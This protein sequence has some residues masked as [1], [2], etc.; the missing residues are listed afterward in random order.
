MS[1]L[2]QTKKHT[3]AEYLA[4]EE[5]AKYRSEYW[6][7]E[8]VAMSGAKIDH[9][10]IIMNISRIL[11]NKLYGK[12][13]LFASEMKVWVKKRNKFFYPD[14]TLICEKPSFYKNRRDTID[15]PKLIVEVLSKSTASFDRAEK[16]LSYQS[17]DS[18]DEY[19]LVSQ[20]KP[21][22]EQYIKRE[23]GNW[24]YK[25]TIGLESTVTFSAVEA[26]LTLQEIYD[27]VEFEEVE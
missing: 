27:L 16:F 9:Q 2:T 1:V 3:P 4:L 25:A 18:L 12:C 15:N 21:L 22:V 13:R 11:G 8:I 20:E 23:D 24:I 17:L 19:V 26:A 10:Q 7:G 5:K 14:I 6:N